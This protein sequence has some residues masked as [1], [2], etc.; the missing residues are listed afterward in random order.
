[1]P[2]IKYISIAEPC[3][4]NWLNMTET[5]KGRHCS[6]CNKI[7]TD[8]TGMT[9]QQIIKYLSGAGAIC[10]RMND[11]Q[12]A[13]LNSELA[14][15]PEPF[16]KW[17]GFSLAASLFFT[18]PVTGAYAQ[19]ISTTQH[20]VPKALPMKGFDFKTINGIIR[21]NIDKTPLPGVI[22]AV[23]GTAIVTVSDI[24]GKYTLNI[25]KYA[26]TLEI[27]YTGYTSQTIGIIP[28]NNI[29]D[30]ALANCNQMKIVGYGSIKVTTTMGAIVIVT[31]RP[32][33]LKR[34]YYRLIKQPVKK[35]F[36]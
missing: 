32:S 11:L 26:D 10:G 31:K 3:H 29:I 21:D 22:I 19:Q 6:N 33:F 27:N 30:I 4:Q 12:M 25:P 23:K 7:V 2:S 16:F 13:G 34:M 28:Y 36:G 14:Y 17:K 35:I 18:L 8:F 5:A 20:P 15:K 9:N 24:N 1:M